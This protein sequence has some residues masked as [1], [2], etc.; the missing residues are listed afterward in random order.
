MEK[1]EKNYVE[2]ILKNYEE[3][4]ITKIDELKSLD[5]KVKKPANIFAYVFGTVG[6]LVLGIGMCAAMN[7]LPEFILNNIE[8]TLLMIIG[9]IVGLVGIIMTVSNYFIYKK[10]LRSRRKKYANDII[11]LTEEI[12]NNNGE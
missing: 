6:A 2:K 10:V 1:L 8:K 9:I 4:E 12:L 3:K 5:K 11:N 7:T